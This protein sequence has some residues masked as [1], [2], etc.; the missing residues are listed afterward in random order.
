[1]HPSRYRHSSTCFVYLASRIDVEPYVPSFSERKHMI[2]AFSSDTVKP[3]SLHTTVITFIILSRLSAF[4]EPIPTSSAYNFPHRARSSPSFCQ[5][6]SQSF[7]A[8]LCSRFLTRTRP[9]R[10]SPS[11]RNLA[12]ATCSTVAKM[13][14]NSSHSSCAMTQP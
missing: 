1:M 2:S 5:A 12:R 10:I 8:N 4:H 7:I 14:L 3:G 9:R 11:L 6:T 13:L